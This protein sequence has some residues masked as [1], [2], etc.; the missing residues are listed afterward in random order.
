MSQFVETIRIENGKVRHIEYHNE[1]FNHTR[2]QFYKDIKKLNLRNCLTHIPKHP[3]IKCRILYGAQV[4]QVEYLPY[5]YKKIESLKIVRDDFINYPYKYIDRHQ[6]TSLYDLRERYDDILIIKNG[7]I[8][9]T[10]YAN[11]ALFKNNEWF[12]PAEPLLAG[13]MRA[14]LIHK[15]KIKACIILQEDLKY[16]SK[17]CVFN[18]MIP[19]GKMVFSTNEIYE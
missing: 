7:M 5:N 13:T 18:A 14:Y 10:S 9:D 12:T 1:R 8:K 16:F 4:E 6:L 17:I 19:F 11:I 15:K 2:Q 3:L